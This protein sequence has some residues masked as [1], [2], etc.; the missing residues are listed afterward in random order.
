MAAAGAAAAGAA[1]A[2]AILAGFPVA[3]SQCAVRL[4]APPLAKLTAPHQ[5]TSAAFAFRSPTCG[6]DADALMLVVRGSEQ[7]DGRYRMCGGGEGGTD[8]RRAAGVREKGAESR[9]HHHIVT[10]QHWCAL[11]DT[12]AA[13]VAAQTS[14]LD[15]IGVGTSM[16]REVSRFRHDLA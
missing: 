9:E 16:K 3:M 8:N 5:P 1:G 7:E 12:D 10:E 6:V 4:A 11:N 13:A 2:A 14:P 15:R